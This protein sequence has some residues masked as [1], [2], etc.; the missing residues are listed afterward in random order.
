MSSDFRTTKPI[1]IVDLFD[2]RLEQFGVREHNDDGTDEAEFV[3]PAGDPSVSSPGLGRMPISEIWKRL[4]EG[5]RSLTDGRGN[6]L[7]VHS[8][9]DGIVDYLSCRHCDPN[10][11]LTAISEAFDTQIL[12]ED[13]PEFWGFKSREEM[14]EQCRA[15]ARKREN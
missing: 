1:L 9:K 12:S 8:A 11:M 6:Y 14:A 15:V 7:S 3:S 5:V 4:A 13:D 2:G 10:R